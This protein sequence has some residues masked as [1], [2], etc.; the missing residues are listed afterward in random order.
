MI[1][2]SADRGPGFLALG[3]SYTIG[4]GVDE[5][6]RWPLQL[7]SRL[8]AQFVDIGAA[9]IIASTGWTTDELQQAIDA[10]KFTPPYALVSLLIG[11][12]NQYRGR[13]L[14]NYASELA[15]LLDFAVGMADGDAG[16]VILVSIPDWGATRF[17]VARQ[18]DAARVAVE[19]DSFNAIARHMGEAHGAHWIDVTAISRGQARAML[20]DDGLHPSADQYTL[21]VDAILPVARSILD[22]GD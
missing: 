18:V 15:A 6:Q 20:A 16:K 3:D 5:A 8:R 14:D 9:E 22:I 2:S 10:R 12:N 17:A 13:D 19:I 7:V 11:V 4:E 21:W 1:E